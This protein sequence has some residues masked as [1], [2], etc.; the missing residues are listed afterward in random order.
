MEWKEL[1][2]LLMENGLPKSPN[3][4]LYRTI[5]SNSHAFHKGNEQMDE[6]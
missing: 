5:Y 3:K 2:T 1:E 6:L 4:R